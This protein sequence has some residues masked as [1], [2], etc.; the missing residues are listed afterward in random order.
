MSK[1]NET[2]H[3]QDFDE[4]TAQKNIYKLNLALDSE[5]KRE[6]DLLK[7]QAKKASLV[8]V[9]RTALVA[10]KLILDH[11]LAG[12]RIIFRNADNSEETLRLL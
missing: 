4:R 2:V 5:A 6:L 11:Q 8:D 7:S 3:H 10:Y 12:G 1:S 9:I